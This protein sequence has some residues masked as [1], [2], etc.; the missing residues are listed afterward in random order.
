[1]RKQ[2]TYQFIW[3]SQCLSR[4]TLKTPLKLWDQHTI[5]TLETTRFYSDE[6]RQ[7]QLSV[8]EWSRASALRSLV[9]H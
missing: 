6:H 8:N 1:V 9:L 3:Y 5:S 2:K 7:R 4:C